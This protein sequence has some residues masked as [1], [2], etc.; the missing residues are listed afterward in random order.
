MLMS[1]HG[2][3]GLHVGRAPVLEVLLGHLVSRKCKIRVTTLGSY[4]WMRM[5]M[6][7]VLTTAVRIKRGMEERCWK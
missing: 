3:A 7:I 6:E 2:T 4:W 5:G 1:E